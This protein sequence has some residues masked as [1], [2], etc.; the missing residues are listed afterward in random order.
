MAA[1]AEVT[2]VV[3]TLLPTARLM[4]PLVAPDATVMPLTLIPDDR[5]AHTGVTAIALVALDTVA[6]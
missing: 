2:T 3:M 4:D 1:P 6:E 5:F